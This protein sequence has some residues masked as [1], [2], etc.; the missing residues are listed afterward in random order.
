M[1]WLLEDLSSVLDL[2]CITGECDLA[3]LKEPIKLISLGPKV[4]DHI[5]ERTRRYN[6]IIG[7]GGRVKGSMQYL[8]AFIVKSICLDD[9]MLANQLKDKTKFCLVGTGL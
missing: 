5:S 3:S 9:A 1:H 2:L 8:A 6:P 7:R 4:L